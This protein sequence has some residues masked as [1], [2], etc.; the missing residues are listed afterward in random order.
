M[1]GDDPG[2]NQMI[3]SILSDPKNAMHNLSSALQCAASESEG[4]RE[5]IPAHEEEEADEEGL[6]PEIDQTTFGKKNNNE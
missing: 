5:D 4:V 6:P 1:A 2:M 3:H